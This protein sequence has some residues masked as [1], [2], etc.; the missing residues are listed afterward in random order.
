M[1]QKKCSRKG[2]IS[3]P[4]ILVA[5][6]LL[7]TTLSI[8]VYMLI[9]LFTYS[10]PVA[11][12]DL[13]MYFAAGIGFLLSVIFLLLGILINRVTKERTST[14]ELLEFKDFT[15][16]I[17]KASSEI[18]VYQ[19]LYNFLNKALTATHTTLLYRNDTSA[20][21]T[22]WQRISN[23]KIP[24]CNLSTKNC[25]LI[26]LGRECCVASIEKDIT[27]TY[28]LSE[29]KK[30]SYVCLPIIE[31]VYPQSIVQLYSSDE[32]FFDSIAIEKIKSYIEIVKPVI[33]SKRTMHV[34]NKK[35]STDKLTKLYNRSFLDPYL[36]NQ[37]E[38]ANLSDQHL[39]L[40]MLD[41]D[42]F[43]SINDTYGHA[44]GD[45]VLSFF[46]ELI[47]KCVRKA[48]TVARYG[49]E[50]FTV[51][52]PSTGIDTAHTVA[53]R[54]RQTLANSKIP[55]KDGVVLPPI[56]CSL[57]ISTYPD[58]ADSKNS[59]IKTADIALYKSKQSGRNCTKVFS[60]EMLDVIN[61]TNQPINIIEA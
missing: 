61:K 41:I 39:S 36:E 2:K 42:N 14:N 51:I 20:E 38:A 58:L 8:S 46:A 26:R 43:K 53:E 50:E 17:H 37:I 40:I 6:F 35:A 23:E 1:S 4:V 21:N 9:M 52:L 30:G 60:H 16:T 13:L 54:I 57:G 32:H 5:S 47:L 45:Y 19:T 44:I 10:H 34:L 48:D 55:P 56:S 31:T 29:H 12:N 15:D 7:S 22:T 49:G 59:L 25:P 33:N 11:L 24:L 28:Q 18:E 27:C 3:L